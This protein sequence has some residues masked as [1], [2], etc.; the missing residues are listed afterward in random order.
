MEP[1]ISKGG[2]HWDYYESLVKALTCFL[3]HDPT[4]GLGAVFILSQDQLTPKLVP[5][6]ARSPLSRKAASYHLAADWPPPQTETDG[7]SLE[8]D[9]VKDNTT[10]VH[11]SIRTSLNNYECFTLATKQNNILSQGTQ[12]NPLPRD[13]SSKHPFSHKWSKL[14]PVFHL[15]ITSRSD[16]TPHNVHP[17]QQVLY[18][19]SS[20]ESLQYKAG[21]P[22][23]IPQEPTDQ[24][25]GDM[26]L[27]PQ[28][29]QGKEV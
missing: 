4:F 1:F 29:H 27:E 23:A 13:S 16:S 14:E 5:Q 9:M 12:A 8:Q 15:W 25:V 3:F 21:D 28:G 11:K 24:Q 26:K 10:R 19:Q 2:W 7:F 18:C 17:Y 20:E 22:S 6:A